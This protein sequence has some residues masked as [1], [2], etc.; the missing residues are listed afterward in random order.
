M[1]TVRHTSSIQKKKISLAQRNGEG[2]ST[3]SLKEMYSLW[4]LI[5]LDTHTDGSEQFMSASK[6]TNKLAF[7]ASVWKMRSQITL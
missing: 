1:K 5:T 2:K 4:Y 6:Y 3:L 7:R